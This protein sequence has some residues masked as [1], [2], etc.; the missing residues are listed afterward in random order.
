MKTIKKLFLLPLLVLLFSGCNKDESNSSSST[1]I[2]TSSST[3]EVIKP[4]FYLPVPE[5]RIVLNRIGLTCS[6]RAIL[7][8]ETINA[9]PVWTVS[10]SSIISL[11]Y[12]GF[13]GK[14]QSLKRGISN[15]TI[16]LGTYSESFDVYVTN[17]RGEV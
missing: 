15:V 14:I 8:D 12:Q 4:L 16:T 2:S 13:V 10:D 11:E 3:S 17:I 9:T 1:I 5:H 6:V 7:L